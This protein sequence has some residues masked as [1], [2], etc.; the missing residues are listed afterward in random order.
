MTMRNACGYPGNKPNNVI[1]S[2]GYSV[3]LIYIFVSQNKHWCSN[4]AGNVL[5]NKSIPRTIE[6]WLKITRSNITGCK[7]SKNKNNV[8]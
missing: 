4:R 3:S 8:I 2:K 1:L 5:A 7:N 6:R